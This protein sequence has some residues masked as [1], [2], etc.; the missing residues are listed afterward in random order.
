MFVLKGS[1]F[2]FLFNND[3]NP[4]YLVQDSEDWIENT[5]LEK[6]IWDEENINL[7]KNFIT[8]NSTIL[9]LGANLGSFVVNLANL[10]PKC[11]FIA[12]EAQKQKF[13]QMCANLYINGLTNVSP[14]RGA[15]T[16]TIESRYL[17]F[18]IAK[19]NNN[20]ASRLKCEEIL[21][22]GQTDISH[23]ETVEALTLD[24]LDIKGE[25]CLIKIDVEGHE[26]N[27]LLG[28]KNLIKSNKPVIIFESWDHIT[29]K[30]P[31]L[32]NFFN[33]ND[34]CVFKIKHSEYIAIHKTK[35]DNYECLKN[36]SSIKLD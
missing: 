17:K 9:D 5:I 13:I 21:T 32:F 10:Y 15:L 33:Q 20:G 29:H 22:K 8:P 3:N 25:V 11:D 19:N 27:V 1:N 18:C 16:D 12:V 36:L 34:Y 4:N 14:Y 7:A 31:Q 28:G 24:S 2:K 35:S 6:G 23:E 26:L 30:K